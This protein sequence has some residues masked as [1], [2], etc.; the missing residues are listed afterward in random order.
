MLVTPVRGN[1]YG[2]TTYAGRTGMTTVPLVAL[3]L[4]MRLPG[5]VPALR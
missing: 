4:R 3:P 1:V 2:A 5:V